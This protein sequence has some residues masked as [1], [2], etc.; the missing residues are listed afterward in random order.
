MSTSDIVPSTQQAPPPSTRSDM[1]DQAYVAP[2]EGQL[3]SRFWQ[4]ASGFWKGRSAWR[5]WPL[6][7]LLVATVLLQLWVQY[8]LNFW[9]RDFF[10]A[11]GRRDA[12]GL[13]EQALRFVPLAAASIFL[14]IVSVW[15]RMTMQ[16]TWREWLSNR[17]YDYWLEKDHYIRLR[18]VPG[19]HQNPEFRIAEDVRIATDLPIDLTIGLFSSILTAITFIG[20]LWSVGDGLAIG[21]SGLM[22]NIPGY[23][24]IA[25]V[26]YSILLSAATLLI[27]RHLVHVLEENKRSEAELRSIGTHLRE[28]G[29]GIA[30]KDDKKDGRRAVGSALK[31]VIAIWRTYC[32]QLMRLTLITH[33]SVLMTPIVGLLLCAPKYLAGAMSLGE[34]VQA[35]AA[36]VI[37]TSAFNWF[38]DNY[39]RLA[40]WASS[41]NRVAS[42]LL[43]LDRIDRA[44]ADLKG[45]EE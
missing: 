18:F 39:A 4:S 11:I 15:G 6:V 10:D 36:F 26:V 32:W 27:A 31:A 43:G 42:L 16:R 9:N 38:T 37:V 44:R 28:T 22:L 29:E 2:D 19:D 20:V 45:S 30:L 5:A 12:A 23:L 13:W 14:A 8:G 24:V 3:L 1:A 25:V 21:F 33:A 17:L 34:V 40:E 41:A 7:V 35:A